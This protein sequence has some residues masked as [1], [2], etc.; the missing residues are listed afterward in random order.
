MK[1][2]NCGGEG[3]FARECPSGKSSSITEQRRGERDN[4]DNRDRGGNRDVKCYKCGRFGHMARDCEDSRDRSRGYDREDRRDRGGYRDRS[5]STR[6]YNCQKYGHLARD[7][8][9]GTYNNIKR[10]SRIATTA[11]K[12]VTLLVIAS[13]PEAIVTKTSNVTD[14]MKQAIW[15]EAA[16]VHL[17]LS[18]T[19]IIDFY[20]MKPS[21]S[22]QY[23]HFPMEKKMKKR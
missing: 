10:G 16:P 19:K 17:H 14:V 2:Y 3:H 11:E 22:I 15:L 12:E 7:C 18:Q 9:G 4:R 21:F 23:Y 5:E 1:C 6:C 20:L 13:R 8:K